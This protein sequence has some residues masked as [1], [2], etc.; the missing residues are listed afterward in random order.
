MLY[1][2]DLCVDPEGPIYIA[3]RFGG[4]VQAFTRKLKSQPANPAAPPNGNPR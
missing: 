4:R 2:M 3:E 1:P